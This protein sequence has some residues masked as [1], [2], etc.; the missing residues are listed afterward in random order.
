M[1]LRW[2]LL[3]VV[4]MSLMPSL[5][6]ARRPIVH[7][8]PAVQAT[9]TDYSIGAA[10]ND[11]A[12]QLILTFYNPNTFAIE[13][14][15]RVV[16]DHID[17][18]WLTV[19]VSSATFSHT[20][21]FS[22]DREKSAEQTARI[23]PSGLHFETIDLGPQTRN[24]PAG[25]YDVRVTWNKQVTTTTMTSTYVPL[26]CGLT[27]ES[28]RYNLP[29]QPASPSKWPY[30]LGG[31]GFVALL[32]GMLLQKRAGAAYARVPCSPL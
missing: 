4:T 15:V 9:P 26:R 30:V 31:F 7:A 6:S 1:R 21:R 29:P 17:Y 16:S 19:E 22:H 23:E 14:P 18:D 3:A 25:T 32:V 11:D 5:A 2:L 28:Y 27:Y 8:S 24:L 20:I 12:N 10:V 13:L